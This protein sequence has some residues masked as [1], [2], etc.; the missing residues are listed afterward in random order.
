MAD[1]EIELGYRI[2]TALMSNFGNSL[3]PTKGGM[4]LDT[5]NCN[6]FV[7]QSFKPGK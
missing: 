7:Y 2:H 3:K 5:D 6:I 1:L 4:I